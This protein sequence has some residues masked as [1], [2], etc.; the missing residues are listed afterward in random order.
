MK[1]IGLNLILGA[2]IVLLLCMNRCQS[3]QIDELQGKV[4]V[5]TG[6]LEK[7]IDDNGVLTAQI[8]DMRLTKQSDL[9]NMHAMTLE[10][11]RIRQMADKYKRMYGAI[12]VTAKI[13]SKGNDTTLVTVMDTV[14]VGDTVQLWPTYRSDIS[15]E[16]RSGFVLANKDSIQY[17]VRESVPL[18][19]AQRMDGG[20]L[21]RKTPVVTVTSKNP[22]VDI[23]GLASYSVKA[24]AHRIVF[25]PQVGYGI[26]PSGNF[27]LYLGAGLTF[28]IF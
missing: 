19:F 21:K 15:G 24:P 22:A 3:N 27:Q 12:A 11:E 5:Y 20:L 4:R 6:E 9:K 26:T 14:V 8:E 2:V 1:R 10:Q 16:Y 18:D 28:R 13:V 7:S 23:T 17:E 25:G